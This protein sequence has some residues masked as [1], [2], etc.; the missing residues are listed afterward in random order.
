MN[1]T[2]QKYTKTMR[3]SR[4]ISRFASRRFG[5]TYA[6]LII[7]GLLL[8][9]SAISLAEESSQQA[10]VSSD[11][12]TGQ[13]WRFRVWL[14]D[15]EI[16]YHNFFLAKNGEISHLHSEASFEYKLLFVSLYDYEHENRE[17]WDGDCLQSIDSH[18][19]ANGQPY[20]VNG[21]RKDGEFELGSSSGETSLPE[22]VMSFAYWNPSFLQQKQLLNTQNGEFLEIQVSPPVFEE[23]EVQGEQRP[24]NRYRLAARALNLDLWYSM[25]EQW[26]ALESET[27]GGRKLRYELL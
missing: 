14:D 20:T 19:D 6:R 8:F 11:P 10:T 22:C 17:T 12:A 21:H 16:G 18:T 5:P 4:L 25:D 26:L 9:V 24:S 3:T 2:T 15:K 7:S 13:S 23:L 1:Q 27:E